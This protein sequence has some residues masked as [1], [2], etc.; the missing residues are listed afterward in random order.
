MIYRNPTLLASYTEARSNFLAGIA[1]V[2]LLMLVS[3]L[4]LFRTVTAPLER[5]SRSLREQDP[6]LIEDL[7]RCKTEFADV[8]SLILEFFQ[9]K[10]ALQTEIE[11][12]RET[13]AALRS[14]E[15]L[16]QATIESTGD[17]ILIVDRDGKVSRSNRRF[18]E[19]LEYFG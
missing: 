4:L 8:A 11:Q 16:L 17:G 1:F 9:Q 15:S 19:L 14:K 2:V 13:E 5:I 7:K 10:H 12:R 6:R 18:A 3:S